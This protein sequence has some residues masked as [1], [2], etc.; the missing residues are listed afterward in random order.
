MKEIQTPSYWQEEKYQPLVK[1]KTLYGN[2]VMIPI[3]YQETWELEEFRVKSVDELKPDGQTG[4]EYEE[5]LLKYIINT[6]N[7]PKA[8]LAKV[9]LEIYQK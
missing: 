1:A 3:G 5:E 7:S 4:L 8:D 2:Q 6:E 9:M